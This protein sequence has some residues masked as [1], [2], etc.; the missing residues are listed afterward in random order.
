MNVV[1]WL[2]IGGFF[3]VVY[4]ALAFFYVRQRSLELMRTASE[5]N[6]TQESSES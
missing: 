5:V 1:N 4:G 3:V 6:L 2:E